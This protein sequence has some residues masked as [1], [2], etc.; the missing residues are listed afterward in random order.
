MKELI[1]IAVFL[2]GLLIGTPVIKLVHDQVR[3]AALQTTEKG[4]PSLTQVTATL[5]TQRPE[6]GSKIKSKKKH[7]KTRKHASKP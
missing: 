6:R 3:S 4:L 7:E 1:S 5:Q 2:V